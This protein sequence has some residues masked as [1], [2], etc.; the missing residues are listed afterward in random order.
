MLES[1]SKHFWPTV[2]L[3]KWKR[4]LIILILSPCVIKDTGSLTKLLP[5]LWSHDW[6]CF[7][8]VVLMFLFLILEHC[9]RAASLTWCPSDASFTLQS[10]FAV[11][12]QYV[13]GFGMLSFRTYCNSLDYALRTLLRGSHNGGWF[14]R[15]YTDTHAR[16]MR[17]SGNGP[18]TRLIAMSVKPETWPCCVVSG[19]EAGKMEGQRATIPKTPHVS[20]LPV[21]QC[22]SP[23]AWLVSLLNP[24]PPI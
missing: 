10:E 7:E 1:A 5:W 9:W 13:G 12:A 8:W 11:S 6:E 15:E 3:W 18:Q 24:P 21:V 20:P 14:W 4:M 2:G 22:L 19:N 23:A 17:C 16:Q